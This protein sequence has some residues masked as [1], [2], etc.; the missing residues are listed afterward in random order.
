MMFIRSKKQARNQKEIILFTKPAEAEGQGKNKFLG[1]IEKF[2]LRSG[3][4]RLS[5]LWFYLIAFFLCGTSEKCRM[6]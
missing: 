3:C 2:S 1:A 4:D 5:Y 6:Y